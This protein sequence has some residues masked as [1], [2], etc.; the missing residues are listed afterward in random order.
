MVFQRRRTKNPR[1]YG[2]V[3]FDKLSG[4]PLSSH[5]PDPWFKATDGPLEKATQIPLVDLGIKAQMGMEMSSAEISKYNWR[6]I[7]K[8]CV[9]GV[10]FPF[11][12]FA[13]S[14]SILCPEMK[15]TGETM[16]RADTYPEALVKAFV[17]SSQNLP[18]SGE[19]FLS[20]RDKDKVPM[21]P[22]LKNLKKLIT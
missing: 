13:D 7:D 3:H 4:L 1:G 9:K 22:L 2:E 11:K 5:L 14:D 12:K 6:S 17:A 19:V 16:G 8:I 21:L 10:V 20:L 18:A 15:S